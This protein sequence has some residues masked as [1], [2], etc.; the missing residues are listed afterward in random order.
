M[1]L[2]PLLS[3]CGGGG[4]SE[5]SGAGLQRSAHNRFFQT[6]L[7]ASSLSYQA[8]YTVPDF[9]DAWGVANRPV[10][11]GGHFWIVGVGS[12][13]EFVGDVRGHADASLGQLTTDALTRVSSVDGTITGVA[14]N[15]AALTFTNFEPVSADSS[16]QQMSD[17]VGG[18]ATMQGSARFIFAI[19]G[20]YISAWTERRQDKGSVLRNKGAEQIVVNGTAMGSA[21][22]GVAV[23]PDMF[24]TLWAADFGSHPKIRQL[25][26]KWRLVPTVGFVNPFG[27]GVAGAVKPGDFVPFNIQALGHQVFVTCAKSHTSAIDVTQF[28]AGEEDSMDAAAEKASGFVPNRGRLVEFDVNGNLTRVHNDEQH[29]NSPW[30]VALAPADFGAFGGALLVGNFGDGGYITACDPTNGN[31]LGC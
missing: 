25:D 7:V 10:G 22:F 27:T 24:D 17:G 4:D 18:F 8:L 16:R 23:R 5:I 20:G 30:G 9:I 28:F 29:F 11:S 3:A 1:T 6:N 2:S 31:F 15:G 12:S 13:W 21:F 19:D 26:V 14:Y